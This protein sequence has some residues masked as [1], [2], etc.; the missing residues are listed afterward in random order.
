MVAALLFLYS[1]GTETGRA[2]SVNL[3]TT[4][5]VLFYSVVV[6]L[7]IIFVTWLIKQVK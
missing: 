3:M 6:T 7:G 4:N 2:L 1:V 5:P